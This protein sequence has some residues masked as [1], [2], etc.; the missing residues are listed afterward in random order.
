MVL[1]TGYLQTA[2]QVI[3]VGFKEQ[4]NA[5]ISQQKAQNE[6]EMVA[7]FNWLCLRLY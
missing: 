5:L 3:C 2:M 4:N 6:H 1:S 7:K